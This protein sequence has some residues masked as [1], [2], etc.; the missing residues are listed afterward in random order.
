MTGIDALVLDLDGVVRHFD[1]GHEAELCRRHGLE[2]GAIAAAAYAP[3]LLHPVITGRTTKAEW[4]TAVGA[5]LGVPEAAEAWGESPTT[6][7][8]A[9]LAVVDEVRATGRP[10]VILTN[11]TDTI[12]AELATLDVVR[13]F[14]GIFN[15]AVI[16]HAKPDRRA[17]AHVCAALDLPPERVAFADDSPAKLVGATELGMTAIAF[18]DAVSLRAWL[19]ALD[20]LA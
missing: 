5:A 2:A 9:V 13:R 16:G 6:L 20:V 17:F 18:T 7:D 19:V 3:D 8:E 1:A 12:D 4:I 14:D 10:V 15:S 11:G